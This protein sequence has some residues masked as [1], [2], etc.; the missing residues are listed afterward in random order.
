MILHHATLTF[1][2]VGSIGILLQSCGMHLS[3]AALFLD[4]IEIG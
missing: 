2:V 4:I 1:S 3:N